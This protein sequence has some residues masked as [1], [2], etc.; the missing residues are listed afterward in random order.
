MPDLHGRSAAISSDSPLQR[1]NQTVAAEPLKQKILIA[2]SGGFRAAI[3]EV[4]P[5]DLIRREKT[6]FADR[7]EDGMVAGSEQ[8][9]NFYELRSGEFRGLFLDRGRARR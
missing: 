5:S 2:S 4:Q 3:R 9:L 7:L 6:V 1:R 8:L